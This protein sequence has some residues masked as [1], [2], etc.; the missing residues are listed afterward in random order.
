MAHAKEMV[1]IAERMKATLATK[2]EAQAAGSDAQSEA[3]TTDGDYAGLL[4]QAGILSPVTK[5][6]AGTDLYHS[7]LA[8]QLADF[9]APAMSNKSGSEGMVTLTDAYCLYNRA[10]GIEMVS[11]ADLR[12]AAEVLNKKKMSIR[13]HQFRSGVL[14][15]KPATSESETEEETLLALLKS[16]KVGLSAADI[17]QGMGLSMTMA[18]E[19]LLEAEKVGKVCRDDSLEGLLFYPNVFLHPEE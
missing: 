6:V 19:A 2:Q 13:L 12:K 11:P 14:V 5:E 18:R 7:Q 15:I 8:G 1:D 10:R 16:S 9:L 4:M 3:T 17:A